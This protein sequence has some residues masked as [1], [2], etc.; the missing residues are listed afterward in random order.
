MTSLKNTLTFAPKLM[1]LKNLGLQAFWCCSD[2]TNITWAVYMAD[3][4]PIRSELNFIIHK[5]K[6]KCR[7][8]F[9]IWS[10]S[11]IHILRTERWKYVILLGVRLIKIK[12]A[13]LEYYLHFSLLKQINL[14]ISRLK[15]LRLWNKWHG[16]YSS[17]CD[18]RL[19]YLS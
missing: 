14:S 6:C 5:K 11:N 9:Y 2:L 19:R 10:K 18:F 4:K 8:Y 15:I 17:K 3:V 1:C 16:N 12:Y 13:I 7:F